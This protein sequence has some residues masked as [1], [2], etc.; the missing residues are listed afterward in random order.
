M[1]KQLLI[2]VL[3][4]SAIWG[5]SEVVLGGF[6][7]EANIPASI[8]LTIIGFCVLA[9]ARAF[10]PVFGV[11]TLIGLSAMCLNMTKGTDI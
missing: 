5:L 1:K 10:F 6:L 9:L 11:A 3:F 7:Y 2:G 4:F 8:C